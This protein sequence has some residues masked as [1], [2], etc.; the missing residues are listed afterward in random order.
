MPEAPSSKADVSPPAHLATI[1]ASRDA[2]V[3]LDEF[4]RAIVALRLAKRLQMAARNNVE[5][6]NRLGDVASR[7]RASGEQMQS[8]LLVGVAEALEDWLIGL[9]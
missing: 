5:A 1:S 9:G 2:Y 4:E 7:L 6:A 8:P 3:V